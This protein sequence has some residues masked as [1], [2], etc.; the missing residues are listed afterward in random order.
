MSGL[1]LL[2]PGLE[3]A[4]QVMEWIREGHSDEAIRERLADPNGAGQKLI[5]AARGRKKR[6]DEY[7]AEG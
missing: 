3:L 1:G 5:D 2:G 6:I 7:K 4:N